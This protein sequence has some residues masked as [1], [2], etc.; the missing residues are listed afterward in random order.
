MTA[1]KMQHRLLIFSCVGASAIAAGCF[2]D[3]FLFLFVGVL[4]AVFG[5]VDTSAL[6]SPRDG[7]VLDHW[8]IH[9]QGRPVSACARAGARNRIEGSLTIRKW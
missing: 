3:G 6:V 1:D 8:H 7:V 9:R 5:G 2:F 4:Y